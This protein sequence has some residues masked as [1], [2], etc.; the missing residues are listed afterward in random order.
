MLY[1][2]IDYTKNTELILLEVKPKYELNLMNTIKFSDWLSTT[3]WDSLEALVTVTRFG[4]GERL[5]PFKKNYCKE[6]DCDTVQLVF[7]IH[8]NN[9]STVPE[10]SKFKS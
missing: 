4:V 6:T 10:S 9:Y 7:E 8:Q 2:V 5:P 1:N 3:V